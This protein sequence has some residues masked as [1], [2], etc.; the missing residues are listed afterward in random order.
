ML[1]STR[2]VHELLP[3]NCFQ[4]LLRHDARQDL[5]LPA[6]GDHAGQVRDPLHLP[7]HPRA[8][9]ALGPVVVGLRGHVQRRR[10]ADD[11]ATAPVCNCQRH[12]H[13]G[14]SDILQDG[15]L[16]RC[17]CDGVTASEVE[18]PTPHALRQLLVIPL[19]G[20]QHL[21]AGVLQRSVPPSDSGFHQ[22]QQT[23]NGPLRVLGEADVVLTDDGKRRFRPHCCL[24][25]REVRLEATHPPTLGVEIWPV[26]VHTLQDAHALEL[27]RD[28]VMTIISFLAIDA[29]QE[30][31]AVHC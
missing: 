20:Q 17:P 26:P 14:R 3:S 9:T 29:R 31:H 4:R 19:F 24:E 27:L 18:G 25:D 22:L 7:S 2:L 5:R 12:V 16:H 23:L 1:R 11:E 28:H 21:A 15:S 10:W 6:V 8:P 13:V 30:R